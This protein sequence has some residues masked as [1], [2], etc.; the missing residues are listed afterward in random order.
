MRI[1]GPRARSANAPPSSRRVEFGDDDAA[2]L[3][4]GLEPRGQIG[5]LADDAS[6]ARLALAH[7][8]ADDDEAGG[9]A[10]AHFERDAAIAG[11][12]VHRFQQREGGAHGAFRVVLMGPG[13]AEIDQ[14][15]VAHQF[16]DIAVEARNRSRKRA[17][18][19]ADQI[20]HIFWIEPCRQR[21]RADEIAEHNR[22]LPPLSGIGRVARWSIARFRRRPDGGAQRCDR[23]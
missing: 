19:R 13:I 10:R 5:R 15:A 23:L 14:R 8:F 16:G 21:S 9:D 12:S 11:K 17:M 6:F 18:E 20:T 1:C 22:Q 7:Q 2:W 4:Q 3:R